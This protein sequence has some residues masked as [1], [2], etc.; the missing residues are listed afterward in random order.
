[1]Q[2][3]KQYNYYK[4]LEILGQS[5]NSHPYYLIRLDF[6]LFSREFLCFFVVVNFDI[7]AQTCQGEE[8]LFHLSI[9]Y[10]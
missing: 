2:V 10:L 5:H 1:M 8:G 3:R 7:S 6:T 9:R 4:Q